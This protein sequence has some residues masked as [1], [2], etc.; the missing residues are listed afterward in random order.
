MSIDKNDVRHIAKLA[1]LHLEEDEIE[2]YAGQLGKILEYAADIQKEP[3][4]EVEPTSHA[5]ALAN[6]FRE[7]KRGTSVDRSRALLNA[8]KEE[9][10]AFMVPR[11]V[12]E[13]DNA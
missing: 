3:L 5:V 4:D 10:N 2:L 12:S 7:D 13:E 9:Q 8:P 6:V 11:I 1:R